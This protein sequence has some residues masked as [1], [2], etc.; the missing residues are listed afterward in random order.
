MTPLECAISASYGLKIR[1]N[2][3]VD[4]EHTATAFFD[5][6]RGHWVV[7]VLRAGSEWP[8]EEISCVDEEWSR[9][10]ARHMQAFIRATRAE[11]L[12][13]LAFNPAWTAPQ[14]QHA[15]RRELDSGSRKHKPRFYAKL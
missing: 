13:Q 5:V 2:G 8:L 15:S 1:A 7:R 14:W 10:L 12:K 3:F 11:S 6:R 4:A 9:S